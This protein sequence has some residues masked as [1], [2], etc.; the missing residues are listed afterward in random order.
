MM[1]QDDLQSNSQLEKKNHQFLNW[2]CFSNQFVV[3]KL[4]IAIT[5]KENK[6]HDLNSM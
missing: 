6:L 5:L 3:Q 2:N 1:E 4:E